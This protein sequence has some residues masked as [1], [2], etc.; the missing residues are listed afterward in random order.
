MEWFLLLKFYATI[1]VYLK[2]YV[3]LYITYVHLSTNYLQHY[4]VFK[5]GMLFLLP[6]R[7]SLMFAALPN[8]PVFNL[9]L[10]I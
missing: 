6:I 9:V 3:S 8:W 4:F 2:N 1:L 7:I 5:T 10:I